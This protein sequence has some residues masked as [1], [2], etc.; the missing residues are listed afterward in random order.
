MD[1]FDKIPHEL[2]EW[3]ADMSDEEVTDAE[4]VEDLD[5]ASDDA[6]DSDEESDED[7][8]SVTSEESG[9]TDDS[10]EVMDDELKKIDESLKKKI[11]TF[12][13]EL[14]KKSYIEIKALTACIRDKHNNIIDDF[15]RTVPFMTKYEKAKILGVRAKQIDSG[16]KPYVNIEDTII[17]S[18]KIAEKEVEEKKLP[19]IIR[20]PIPNGQSE[21]WKVKDLELLYY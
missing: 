3:G 8:E 12:C 11:I 5:E 15:H 2:K 19:F 21:Y 14:K 7:E 10:E 9:Y 13:P 20:R 1:D 4:E 18:Y 17:D 6:E 16:S